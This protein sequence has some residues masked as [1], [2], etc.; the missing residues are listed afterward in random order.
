MSKYTTEVRFICENYHGL[1]ESVGYKDID[2]VLDGCVDKIFENYPIFDESY[3]I[4]LNKKILKHYYTREISEETVGLWLFRLNNRMNEIMP[5]YNQLYKSAT[6]EFNPL[7]D[8][9][10]TTKKTGSVITQGSEE[11]SIVNDKTRD[12]KVDETSVNSNSSGTVSHVTGK[13]ENENNSSSAS[14]G[15]S[16]NDD[17]YSRTPQGGLAGVE[18]GEYLTE[19]RIVR[20][21]ENNASNTNGKEKGTQTSDYSE[22]IDENGIKNVGKS[23]K[24]NENENEKRSANNTVNTLDEYI[25]KVSGKRGGASYSQMIMEYRQSILNIDMM[26]ID[27]LKDLFFALW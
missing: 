6:L 27:A 5:Y 24:A 20:N 15:I 12:Y 11:S 14:N 2:E 1:T 9:D 13:N 26:V 10:Y 7:Y 3:R 18:S 23:G 25:E 17:L 21:N 19:A 16:Q 22:N 4:G 8:F